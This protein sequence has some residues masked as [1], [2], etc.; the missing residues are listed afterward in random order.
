MNN[1][2]RK[3]H[4]PTNTRQFTLCVSVLIINQIRDFNLFHLISFELSTVSSWLRDEFTN[5]CFTGTGPNVCLSSMEIV[6]HRWSGTD[7]KTWQFNN[8]GALFEFPVFWFPFSCFHFHFHL[9][10]FSCYFFV[11]LHIIC[12]YFF[13]LFSLFCFWVFSPVL[14]WHR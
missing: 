14:S 13:W 12:L 9:I 10:F 2:I 7:W 8:S 3:F 1:T 4:Q 6:S 11:F 5:G